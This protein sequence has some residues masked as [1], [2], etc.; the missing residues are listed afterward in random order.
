MTKIEQLKEDLKNV[1]GKP[2]EVYARIVGY[3]R[4]VA[5]WNKGKKSEYEERVDFDI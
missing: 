3:Y 1:K 4:S 2:C 5:N